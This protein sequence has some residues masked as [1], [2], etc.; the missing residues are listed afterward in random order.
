MTQRKN[1]LS[2]ANVIEYFAR[3]GAFV[4]WIWPLPSEAGI[5]GR[6]EI[7]HLVVGHRFGKPDA[8]VQSQF[9]RKC[10]FPANVSDNMN[11]NA[12]FDSGSKLNGLC[13]GMVKS[14]I[15]VVSS[16][17]AE[18]QKMCEAL[19]KSFRLLLILVKVG[20]IVGSMAKVSWNF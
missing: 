13:Q 6:N 2:H 11:A 7:G 14:A 12:V 10:T 15:D 19:L 16:Q 5:R 20:Q 17:S 9:F 1:G 8:G 4:S 18:I 3:Y